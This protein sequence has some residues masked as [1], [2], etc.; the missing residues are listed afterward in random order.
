MLAWVNKSELAGK[1][2]K[3]GT[4]S[5]QSETVKG[6]LKE[7]SMKSCCLCGGLSQASGGRPGTTGG[8]QCWEIQR[9][10]EYRME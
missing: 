5:C 3:P 10:I 6:E 1:S 2:E 4:F 8:Q 9:R 7:K